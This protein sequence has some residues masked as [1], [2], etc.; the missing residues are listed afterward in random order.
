MSNYNFSFTY[1]NDH[2]DNIDSILFTSKGAF[3]E[4]DEENKSHKLPPLYD[5]VK[6]LLDS[7]SKS[8]NPIVYVA[9]ND[10]VLDHYKQIISMYFEYN[11]IK[12]NIEFKRISI[13]EGPHSDLQKIDVL[14]TENIEGIDI[15][16]QKIRI[17]ILQ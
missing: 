5:N 4:F 3:G 6:N 11:E 14:V 13:G 2:C 17:E 16:N 9:G 10:K 15:K 12:N 7:L 1:F 8:K